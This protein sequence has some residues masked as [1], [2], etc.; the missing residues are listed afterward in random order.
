MAQ[1]TTEYP[2][3]LSR[4]LAAEMVGMSARYIDRLRLSGEL[5]VYT[6]MGGGKS[7]FF[8]DD[9]IRHFKLEEK[10]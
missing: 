2:R 4:T 8:R 3:L 10:K 1:Q 6:T 5:R 9:L 7:M